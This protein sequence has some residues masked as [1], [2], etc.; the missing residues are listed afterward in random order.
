MARYVPNMLSALRII[1]SILLIPFIHIRMVFIFIYIAIGITDVLDGFIARKLGCESEFG[2]RLDS[3]ADLVFY[4]IYVFT[5]LKLYNSVIDSAHLAAL[6]VIISIR[7]INILITKL[8]Y[9]KVVFIHTLANKISGIILFLMPLMFLFFHGS[10]LIWT[11]LAIVLIAAIEELLITA[12]YTEPDLNRK[13][14]LFK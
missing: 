6:A 14:V 7:L 13:S 3:A 11:I 4:S 10:V 9:K 8:K 2:A 12:R 1:L 5:F